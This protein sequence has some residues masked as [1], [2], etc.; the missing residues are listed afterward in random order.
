MKPDV[1]PQCF[2]QQLI[3]SFA[4]NGKAKN[5]SKV[6]FEEKVGPRSGLKLRGMPGCGECFNIA[7]IDVARQKGGTALFFWARILGQE[8]K[9]SAG[10]PVLI[11]YPHRGQLFLERSLSSVRSTFNIGIRTLGFG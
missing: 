11:V 8:W 3:C 6:E 1:W 5:S 4:V 7:S 9:R 10:F 2:P